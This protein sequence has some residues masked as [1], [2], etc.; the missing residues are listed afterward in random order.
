VNA[1]RCVRAALAA[2]LLAVASASPIEAAG[3]YRTFESE[4]LRIV[5]DS[6]WVPSAAPGYLPVRLEITNLGDDREIEIVGQGTRFSRLLPR[7]RQSA[8]NLRYRIRLASGDR[9]RL[10]LPVSASGDTDNMQFQLQENGRT[11][12]TLGFATAHRQTDVSA[13]IVVAPDSTYRDSA[14]GWAR[15]ARMPAGMVRVTPPAAGVAPRAGMTGGGGVGSAA[16]TGPPLDFILEPARL[17]TSW[18]GYT[19][20]EAV[21]L[22]PREWEQLDE[23]QRT[24]ILTWVAAGGALILVDAGLETLFPD[25]SGRPGTDGSTARHVLGRILLATSDGIEDAGF[26]TVVSEAR[27]AAPE[28]SFALPVQ[29]NAFIPGAP[30]FRLPIPGVD[31][32]PTSAYLTILTVFAILIG[33]VNHVVLKRRRQQALVVLTTPLIAAAFI[34][35]LAGYVVVVEGFDVKARA[36]SFTRLD[37]ERSQSVTRAT[38]SLYAAGRAPSGGLRFGR[39]TAVFPSAGNSTRGREHVD[40]TNAQQFSAGAIDARAPASF[41]TVSVRAARERLRVSRGGSGLRVTNGLGAAVTQL[42]LR[43]AGRAYRLAAP[44]AAGATADLHETSASARDLLASGDSALSRFDAL[45][46][47]QPEE[48]YLAVLDRSPFWES[49]AGDVDERGSFHLVLGTGRL[50]P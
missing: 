23:P 8:T 21:A 33:P 42:Q 31:A 3:E 39:E 6:E 11:V 50:Q 37:Q 29:S 22:G 28:P 47:S 48:S 12:D 13:L 45:V 18:L 16:P 41:E 43:T 10:T 19:S 34:V 9:V 14:Q 38:A 2:G 17:P 4:S 44:L 24:A 7:F 5:F 1:H 30:G 25:G 26:D 35:L 15:A 32:I 20:V 27:S 40:F 46:A 36:V 49:G